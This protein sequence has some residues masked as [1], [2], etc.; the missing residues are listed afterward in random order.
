MKN[1]NSKTSLNIASVQMHITQDQKTNLKTMEEYLQHI[2]NTFPQI[3]MVVFPEL[4]AMS[5]GKSMDNDAEEI[6]GVLT[7]IFSNWAKKYKLWI[8]PGSM[9]ERSNN[10]IYNTS[11]IYSPNGELIGHYRKRYP[12]RPYEK[13]S[14]GSKSLVFNVDG[15]GNVGIMIC[16]DIWFPEVARELVHLGAELIV[17]PTMTTTG[18]RNQ[19]QII[20]QATAITQQCYV[21]SCNGVGYGGV[22]G[23]QI[24]DPEGVV[25]QNNGEGS[26]LQTC[27]IDFDH[28]RK[29]REIGVAGVT[30]PLKAFKDNSQTFSV[31]KK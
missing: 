1:K 21:V 16:Y 10:K 9:Y 4:C 12:W 2:Q 3:D 14:S 20:S 25:L 15:I 24:I 5:V 23:S 6:P 11:V 13:T 8:I 18:D 30:R 17:V 22:G 31:Y 29:I 19:E 26:C 7:S 27:V 28:I